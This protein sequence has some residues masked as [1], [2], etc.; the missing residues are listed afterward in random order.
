MS[1]WVPQDTYQATLPKLGVRRSTQEADQMGRQRN[2]LQVKEQETHPERNLNK[3]E[4]S[5]QLDIEFR[6]MVIRM[7]KELRGRMDEIR[8]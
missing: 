3:V 7:L 5:N 6:T 4:A 8:T 1:H 2:M